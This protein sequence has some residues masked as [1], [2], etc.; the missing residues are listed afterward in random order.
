VGVAQALFRHA[1]GKL[2]KLKLGE[3]LS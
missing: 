1:K 3:A 2:K